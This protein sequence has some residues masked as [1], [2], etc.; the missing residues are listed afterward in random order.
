MFFLFSDW[1]YFQGTLKF[2]LFEK[3]A[4]LSFCLVLIGILDDKYELSSKIKLLG[5]VLVA[6][7]CW[8]WG[9]Q[10][11]SIF[12][13]PLPDSIS[14]FLTTFWIISFINAFNLIDGMDG[15]ATG[16]AIIS[17]LCMSVIF[18]VGHSPNDTVIILSLV[19]ACLGFLIYNFHPAKIFLGDTGSMFLGFIFAIIGIISSNKSVAVTSILVPMLAA[20]VPIFDVILAIWRRFTHKLINKDSTIE[21]KENEQI[22][23]GDKKHL[24]HRFLEKDKN[25]RKSVIKIYFLSIIFALIAVLNIMQNNLIKGLSYL[26]MLVL[27][28]TLVDRIAHIELWNTGKVILNGL[29]IPRKSIIASLLQPVIDIVIVISF[30]LFCRFLFIHSLHN[31]SVYLSWYY[32]LFFTA[33]PIIL[34][35]HLAKIYKRSWLYGGYPDYIYL[36]KALLLG[37]FIVFALDL[38]RGIKDW[39]SYI[40]ERLLFFSLIIIII[41]VER[42]FLRYLKNELMNQL[43][44]KKENNLIF[45]KILLYG[46]GTDCKYYIDKINLNFEK[47]PYKIIGIIDNNPIFN[48]QFVYGKKVLGR[49][50]DISEIYKMN[51]FDKLT[52]TKGNLKE[53]EKKDVISFCENYNIELTEFQNREIFPVK[54]NLDSSDIDI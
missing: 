52:I 23:K 19:G 37:F 8:F 36:L 46:I 44:E 35:L 50:S 3:L 20:G 2:D 18:A 54:T 9:I 12:G 7:G 27:I 21:N 14:L 43:H 49:I 22:T 16:L 41:L 51:K 30:Y 38:I 33:F 47:K 39:Q 5:Q 28:Y 40:A 26:L 53:K 48:G 32:V 11:S 13:I 42:L 29:D 4:T 1:G 10:L 24:H 6:S 45:Q 34:I 31:E 15:L 17:A 25:Q